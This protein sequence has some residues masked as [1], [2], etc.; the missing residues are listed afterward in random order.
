MDVG[1]YEMA[2]EYA[3]DDDEKTAILDL[4]KATLEELK[5]H[6]SV[7]KEWG[8]DPNKEI[9]PNPATLKYTEFVLA[10]AKGKVDGGKGPGQIATPFEKTKIAA[11]TIG[12]MT[13]CM[14]LYAHLGK[15]LQMFLSH[16]GSDHPYKKWIEYYSSKSFEAE[17]V[18]IEELLDKLSVPLTGEELSLIE[19]LYLQAMKLETEFFSAQ[20]IAQQSVVPLTKL[21]DPIEHLS[22]FSDFDLTCTIVDSSAI[23]AEIAILTGA[24]VDQ[25][26]TDAKKIS[27]DMRSSWDALSSK[28]TEEYEACI[29]GLLPKE[30]ACLYKEF[31]YEHLYK[32]LEQ[33]ANFEKRAN[34]RVVDSGML[35]GVN[36][37]D[38][39]RAGEHLKLHDGC[40]DFFQK[41][42]KKETLT[43]NLH[44]LSYCWCADLIRSAFS[45][46]GCLNELSIHSNEFNFEGSISTGEIDIKMQSPLD[47]VEAFTNV[48]N[49]NSG[50]KH[51]SVYIGDSVGDLLCLL[52]ADVGIV[53]GS[54]GSLRRVGRQFGVTFVPLFPGVVAKQREGS[55]WRG[56]SGTLYMASNWSEIQAFV[57]GA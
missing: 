54:S 1:R 44:I 15:E 16:D 10:T 34:T 2:A 33:L 32:S 41:I 7:M 39:K 38:I 8:V 21:N 46:V 45:S 3:D 26:V 14:R 47:K 19:K 52:K 23:L 18:Q 48:L 31:D 13:P 40:K 51:L 37:D 27:S 11:Y 12:A 30:E 57:L 53:V 9:T 35:R 28:Y 36:L 49:Q 50:D 24:K 25:G 56:L 20:P 22:I 6:D 43:V 42:V 17:A 29:E 5:L 55:R 4:R